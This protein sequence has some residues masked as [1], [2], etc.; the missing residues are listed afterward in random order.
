MMIADCFPVSRTEGM[1]CLRVHA[2]PP[3][4]RKFGVVLLDEEVKRSMMV[5][6]IF[7]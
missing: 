3:N 1:Q 5:D 6:L 2:E 4:I 7:V